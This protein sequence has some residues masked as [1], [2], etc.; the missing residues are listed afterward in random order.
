[1]KTAKILSVVAIGLCLISASCKNKQKTNAPSSNTEESVSADKP[2]NVAQNATEG[3]MKITKASVQKTIPGMQSNVRGIDNFSIRVEN[4]SPEIKKENLKLIADGY[5]LD[6]KRISY[7]K[8]G[9]KEARL[10]VSRTIFDKDWR[11]GDRPPPVPFKEYEKATNNME[12]MAFLEITTNGK[13][14]NT[15]PAPLERKETIYAP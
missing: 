10:I 4:L 12:G 11:A 7:P 8:E 14:I 2:S 6:I 1:M 9:E 13:T 5:R 15:L 3:D